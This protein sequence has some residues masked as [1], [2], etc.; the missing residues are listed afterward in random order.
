MASRQRADS[1][2][3]VLCENVDEAAPEDDVDEEVDGRV[4]HFQTVAHVDQ[5]ELHL[6]G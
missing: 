3:E 5:V 6:Y 4:E 1:D 2:A